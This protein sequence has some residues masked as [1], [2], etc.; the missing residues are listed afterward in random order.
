MGGKK[1]AERDFQQEKRKS[2]RKSGI[3]GEGIPTPQ[4]VE[5]NFQDDSG[6][7]LTR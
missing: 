1:K 7:R 5:G 3:P 2:K 4:R 6:Q